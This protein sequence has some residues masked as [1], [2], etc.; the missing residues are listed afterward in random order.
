[1]Q[2]RYSS[3]LKP[4]NWVSWIPRWVIRQKNFVFPL[5]IES[6]VVLET[7]QSLISN[8][9]LELV[10]LPVGKKTLHNKCVY[11]VRVSMMVP[12]DTK[13]ESLL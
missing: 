6:F 5:V 4:T 12:R 2:R 13:L 11:Q 3:I 8:Q 10:E 7:Q 1:M 9:T